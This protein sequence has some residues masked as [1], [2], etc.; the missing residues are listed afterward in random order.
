[1]NTVVKN[2][3]WIEVSGSALVHNYRTIKRLVRPAA[4]MAVVKANAYGHGLAQTVG[5]LEK[6]TDVSWYGVDSV[7]EALAV[8]KLCA[9]K[10]V[11]VL[12]YTPI[13][14]VKD[15]VKAGISITTYNASALRE[16]NRAATAKHP[17]KIHLKIETGLNRQGVTIDGLSDLLPLLRRSEHVWLEGISTHFANIEDTRDPTE[18]MRQLGLYER[19]LDSVRGQGLDPF[20]KHTACSAAA[21]LYPETRFNLIRLGISL[22]GFWPSGE[23]LVSAK[24]RGINIKLKPVMTWKTI[25]AQVKTVKRG[26]AVGYGLSESMTR[27]AKVAILPIGYYDGFDR[28]GMSGNGQAII[29]GMR[30]RVIGRVAMNMCMVDVTD[31]GKIKEE[32]EVV[33]IGKQGSEII[34]AEQLAQKA[35]TINYEIVARLNPLIPRIVI[36]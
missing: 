33:L 6:N 7:D 27:D 14:R 11:L 29:K 4:V 25:V 23:T 26:M 12:G 16:A 17:A 21:I 13:S 2:K 5:I 30:C 19:A 31:I 3:T 1:M 28:V 34:T 18:A 22:Y 15:A 32:D 10:P 36:K 24:E 35:G 20:W 9:K 8:R